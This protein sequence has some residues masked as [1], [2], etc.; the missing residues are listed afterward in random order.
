MPRG[1][2]GIVLALKEAG[3]STIFGI[4][5]IHNIGLYESLRHESSIRHIGCRHEAALPIWRTVMPGEPRTG[6]YCFVNRAGRRLYGFGPARS[7]G[8]LLAGPDD[9]DQYRRRQDRQRFGRPARTGRTDI[10]LSDHYQRGDYSPDGRG[11]VC[12]RQA[13]HRPGAGRPAR[14][15]LFG[16]PHRPDGRRR[17][18]GD[19]DTTERRASPAAVAP[20]A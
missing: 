18:G 10:S 17:A 8:Q 13:R 7:L 2:D 9:Y 14:P 11:F 19:S 1:A 6:R 20:P 3:V 16:S 12:S 15:G 5:S 4:P